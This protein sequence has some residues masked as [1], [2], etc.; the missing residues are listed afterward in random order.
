MADHVNEG[1]LDKL[2]FPERI[3]LLADHLVSGIAHEVDKLY[4]HMNANTIPDYCVAQTV[5][6]LEVT[7]QSQSNQSVTW[8]VIHDLL[9]YPQTGGGYPKHNAKQ[10]I[11]ES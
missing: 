4:T 1:S 8:V 3:F 9:K 5:V 7:I 6:K 10:H 2:L 11:P